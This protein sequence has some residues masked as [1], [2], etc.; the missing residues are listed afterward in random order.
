MAREC[1]AHLSG[2]K[3]KNENKPIGNKGT[4]IVGEKSPQ[5]DYPIPNGHS[6]GL[7]KNN[8]IGVCVCV[9]LYVYVHVCVFS[10]KENKGPNLILSKKEQYMK[11]F[12]RI[13]GRLKGGKYIRILKIKSLEDE[14]HLL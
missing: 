3:N 10:M 13:K 4:L 8:I 1:Q 12:P 5:F 11:R 9:S 7:A 6:I 14:S 2:T